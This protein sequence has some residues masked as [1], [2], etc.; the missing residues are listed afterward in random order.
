M[1][2]AFGGRIPMHQVEVFAVMVGVTLDAGRTRGSGARKSGMQPS[3]VLQL[4]R[5]LTMTIDT[6]K[7]GRFG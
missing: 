5:N 1:I 2:E 6:A 4:V 7:G 3:I